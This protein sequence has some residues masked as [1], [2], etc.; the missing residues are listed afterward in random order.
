MTRFALGW[1]DEVPMTVQDRAYTSP[2]WYT[3]CHGV[4][5]TV[6]PRWFRVSQ[7]TFFDRRAVRA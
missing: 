3:P 1:R 5:A 7:G 6:T 4:N 2:T